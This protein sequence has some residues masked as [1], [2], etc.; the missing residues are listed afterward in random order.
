MDQLSP[1]PE[2]ARQSFQPDPVGYWR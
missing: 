1:H 2:R